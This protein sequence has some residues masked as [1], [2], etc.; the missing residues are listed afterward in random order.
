MFEVSLAEPKPQ[1]VVEKQKQWREVKRVLEEKTD[2]P[3]G[4]V[5]GKIQD[6]EAK[7]LSKP[8]VEKLLIAFSQKDSSITETDKNRFRQFLEGKSIKQGR[9]SLYVGKDWCVLGI[10]VLRDHG[11]E[12]L[13]G[14][15]EKR[16]GRLVDSKH[17]VELA[18]EK[19][20]EVTRM[21]DRSKFKCL[22]EKYKEKKEESYSGVF[23][24]IEDP[25]KQKQACSIKYV[26]KAIHSMSI[27]NGMKLSDC[28]YKLLSDKDIVVIK[29]E[30]FHEKSVRADDK[31]IVGLEV[32]VGS[33]K[34]DMIIITQCRIYVVEIKNKGSLDTKKSPGEVEALRIAVNFYQAKFPRHMI[35]PVYTTFDS[36][37]VF[38][39]TE[40]K[41]WYITFD[42]LC[43]SC[44]VPLSV[45]EVYD[46]YEN[47][48]NSLDDALQFLREILN[49]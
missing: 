42:D 44:G 49:E 30:G 26:A 10:E 15:L 41:H 23:S 36:N 16:F 40:L 29:G 17:R 47:D 19:E 43:D 25:V 32:P 33:H 45:K 11:Y 48:E 8:E 39:N 5:I 27:S 37:T 4:E 20:Q 14:I 9:R 13:V 34:I 12:G 38:K 7:K 3:V 28:I 46:C 35:S 18:S 1:R 21:A 6:P 24:K 22:I 2:I 31:L